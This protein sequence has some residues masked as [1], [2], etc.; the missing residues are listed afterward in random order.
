MT[1]RKSVLQVE[2]KRHIGN[3][4]VNIVF[5]ANCDPDNPS[6]NPSKMKS[7]FT[8]MHT[9]QTYRYL[10]Y[11]RQINATHGCAWGRCLYA[12]QPGVHAGESHRGRDPFLFGPSFPSVSLSRLDIVLLGNPLQSPRLVFRTHRLSPANPLS[13]TGWSPPKNFLPPG[14]PPAPKFVSPVPLFNPLY[15][16]ISSLW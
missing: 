1:Y 14:R 10:D 13:V 7:Q 15:F 8:R 2:R 16:Q 11:S 12:P 5:E 6:F 3:D 9:F 4:I